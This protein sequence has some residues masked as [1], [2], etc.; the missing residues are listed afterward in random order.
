[1]NQTPPDRLR[2]FAAVLLNLIAWCASQAGAHAQRSPTC[3]WHFVSP[4]E[5]P[6]TLE[7]LASRID[8]DPDGARDGL[9]HLK[10]WYRHCDETAGHEAVRILGNAHE[11]DGRDPLLRALLGIALV[12]GP[13]VQVARAEG[14]TL[15]AVHQSSNAERE[16]ARLLAGVVWDNG[17]PEAALELAAVATATRSETSLRL[18][19][20][21]IEALPDGARSAA[22]WRAL[23]EVEVA[24]EDHAAARRAAERAAALGDG[25]GARVLGITRLL[26]EDD[27]AGGAADY[28][29]GL[30]SDSTAL[31]AYFDDLRLLLGEDELTEWADLKQGRREW[32]ERKWDWRAAMVGI[33]VADRLA[34]HHR[35]LAHALKAY[36]RHSYRGADAFTAIMRPQA[37]RLLPLDDRG[38]IYLRHGEPESVMR[39]VP[40]T[41]RRRELQQPY[42]LGW[43]YTGVGTAGRLFEF[44]KADRADYFL[45]EPV[46]ICDGK[47]VRTEQPP[48]SGYPPIGDLRDWSG[49]VH[50]FDPARGMYYL[51]CAANVQRAQMRY[52]QVRADARSAALE[53]WNSETAVPAREPLGVSANVYAFRGERATELTAYL[54]V[55]AGKLR[56]IRDADGRASY[57]LE[58]LFAAG[59]P[60]TERVARA[61]T[62]IAFVSPEPLPAD[63]IVGTAII[64]D[65]L[66]SELARLTLGV[67]NGHNHEQGQVLSATHVVPAFPAGA[68]GLSDLVLAEARDGLLKRGVHRL[69]P[70]PGNAVAV[71]ARFRLYYELY[72]VRQG[73]PLDVRLVI[74]PGREE[75]LLARLR[76]LLDSRTALLVEYR[77]EAAPDRDVVRAQREIGAQLEPGS[78][79]LTLTVT[80][81]RTKGTA[82]AETR[83]VVVERR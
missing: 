8:G 30:R 24:R 25:R 47:D 43:G 9:A 21:A 3:A 35:R 83:L 81:A 68:F 48:M 1:M 34:E 13:E 78:Y 17:W 40:S 23:A 29:R 39:M 41:G 14:T 66:P 79:T 67:T 37:L 64:V 44:D 11:R 31:G 60:V 74:A 62:A 16:G 38:L 5:V 32:I 46:Q 7:R 2:H 49:T 73:D 75:S 70:L 10:R 27:P 55:P 42:R 59:D 26:T 28:F 69:A 77:E 72:G 20:E 18:A 71:G 56:S 51:V 65:V 33:R 57:A 80:N 19:A 82:T 36:P 12:R 63:A 76:D 58:V 61:D 45:A 54:F 6:P 53:A 4:Q 22:V 50:R 52:F 15:R